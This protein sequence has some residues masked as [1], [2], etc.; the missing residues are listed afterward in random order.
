MDTDLAHARGRQKN[1]KGR[2]RQRCQLNVNNANNLIIAEP[3]TTR[4][5][6]KKP[7]KSGVIIT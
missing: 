4:D 5:Y 2:E 1:K 3:G 6:T 7:G